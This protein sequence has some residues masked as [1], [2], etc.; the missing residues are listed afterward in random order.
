MKKTF[1]EASGKD[2]T[3]KGGSS[4]TARRPG[5]GESYGPAGGKTAHKQAEPAPEARMRSQSMPFS[6]KSF[7][8]LLGGDHEKEE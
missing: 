2:V 4:D 6:H 7:G 1:W 3:E 5:G 8:R